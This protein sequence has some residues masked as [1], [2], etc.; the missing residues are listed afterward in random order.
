MPVGAEVRSRAQ[1]VNLAYVFE[2]E[3]DAGSFGVGRRLVVTCKCQSSRKCQSCTCTNW[4]DVP[5][6]TATNRVV[7]SIDAANGSAFYR[8]AFP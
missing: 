2:D 6:S 1:A 4:A 5:G 7:V 3:E 8:L